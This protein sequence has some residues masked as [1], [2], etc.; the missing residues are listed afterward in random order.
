MRGSRRAQPSVPA[1]PGRLEP[2]VVV[3][4]FDFKGI[5]GLPEETNAILIVDANAELTA[6]ISTKDFQSVSRRNRKFAQVPYAVQ[7]IQLSSCD[8]PQH[9][10]TMLAGRRG[11]GSIKNVLGAAVSK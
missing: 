7:L 9:P 2:I 8:G 10:G 11:V 5:T 1:R 6:A 3:R 4:D